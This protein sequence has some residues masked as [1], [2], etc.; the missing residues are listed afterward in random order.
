MIC[1]AIPTEGRRA[2][3]WAKVLERV[4][5]HMPEEGQASGCMEWLGPSSGAAKPKNGARGH[6]YPRMNLDGATVAVHKVMWIL[7][8]GPI[9]PRKQ[10]DHTCR[11]RMC[12]NPAH[13][14]MVTH[15]RNQKRRDQAR[16]S[17]LRLVA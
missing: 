5:H 16:E 17:T 3:I 4:R 14:E 6:G 7:I 11:R 2:R 15:K 12:V 10:L 1:E 13:L 8:N 9:P